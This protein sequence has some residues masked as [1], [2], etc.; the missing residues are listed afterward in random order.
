MLQKIVFIVLFMTS[1]WVSAQNEQLAL[2]Y[3]DDGEFEKAITIFEENL[4][5]Q[6]SNFFFFQKT[7]ECYQQL[8]QYNKAEEI[9][10]KRKEKYK[11][12]SKKEK[13]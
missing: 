12:D 5:K 13:T 11:Q 3:F 2:Q 7:L 4:Q 8:K 1:F 9:I 10:L 6:P